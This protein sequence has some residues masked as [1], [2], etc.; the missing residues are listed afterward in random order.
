M[1]LAVLLVPGVTVEGGLTSSIKTIVLAGIV[2]GL[3]NFFI[4][5]VIKVITFPLRMITLG[6]FGIIINMFIVWGIDILFTPEL[7]IKGFLPLLLTALIVWAA[8]LLVPKK[9]LK[10]RGADDEDLEK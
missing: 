1:T 9:K 2:L 5:P 10:R 6:L 4:K 3:V 8:N 7:T